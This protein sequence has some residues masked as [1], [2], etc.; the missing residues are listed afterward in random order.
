MSVPANA[1]VIEFELVVPPFDTDAKVPSI[2]DE[3][4]VFGEVV[5]TTVIVNNPVDVF[6]DES[7]TSQDTTVE[8]NG[9]IDPEAGEHVAVTSPSTKSVAV[10]E[11]A[12]VA[13]DADVAST[14]ISEGRFSVGMVVSITVILN[15]AVSVLS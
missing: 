14:I 13:P 10:A 6:S 3:I 2:A 15:E 1:N 11:Y 8:P 12:T 5:S 9:N 7:V 4:V